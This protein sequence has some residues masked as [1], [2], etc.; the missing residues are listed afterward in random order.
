MQWHKVERLILVENF[1]Q[2]H[3][4]SLKTSLCWSYHLS[5]FEWQRTS[6]NE[7]VEVLVPIPTFPFHNSTQL[8]QKSQTKMALWQKNLVILR[9]SYHCAELLVNKIRSIRKIQHLIPVIKY[10]SVHFADPY[11]FIKPYLQNERIRPS[12]TCLN[13]L[14]KWMFQDVSNL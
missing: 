3:V 10:K 13:W 2:H 5:T 14:A 4:R 9:L 7:H 1:S 11:S 8:S 12:A 6:T